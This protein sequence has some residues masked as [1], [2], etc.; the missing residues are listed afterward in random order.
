MVEGIVFR[1]GP[2]W[3]GVTFRG[4]FNGFK[5]WRGQATRYDKH[6][7]VYRGASS[8]QPWLLWLTD[9]ETRPSAT[10]A[11]EEVA[12]QEE[13]DEEATSSLGRAGLGRRTPAPTYGA[14]GP[15][16]VSRAWEQSRTSI[17][18]TS[19]TASSTRP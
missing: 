1:I 2:G 17:A 18:T 12:R 8:S 10:R 11:E 13:H 4:T 15:I 6:V 7:I 14:G 3:R 16:Y 5:H 19:T 9:F